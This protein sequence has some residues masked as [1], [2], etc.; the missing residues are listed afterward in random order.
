MPHRPWEKESVN[1]FDIRT[2]TFIRLV[3]IARLGKGDLEILGPKGGYE[4]D[5][6]TDDVRG[7]QAIGD[8]RTNYYRWGTKYGGTNLQTAKQFREMQ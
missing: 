5:Q 4:F 8:Q 7:M 2:V 3:Q 6:E 1:G